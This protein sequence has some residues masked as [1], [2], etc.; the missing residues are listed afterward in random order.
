MKQLAKVLIPPTQIEV[1]RQVSKTDP[2]ASLNA[3]YGHQCIRPARKA[4]D[5]L[6]KTGTTKDI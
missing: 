5:G 4:N 1:N 2:A 6:D 3:I